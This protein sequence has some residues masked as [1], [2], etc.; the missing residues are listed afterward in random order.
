MGH[1]EGAINIPSD[2]LTAQAGKLP[3]DANIATVCN[4]GEARSCNAA[5]QLHHMGYEK[6]VP[7]QG[8]RRAWLEEKE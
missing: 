7:L 6:A 8:G 5:E 4:L 3:V 2:Q 1:V